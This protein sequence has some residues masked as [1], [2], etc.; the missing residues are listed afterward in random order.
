M[1]YFQHLYSIILRIKHILKHILINHVSKILSL[2][3]SCQP[4]PSFRHL[5]DMTIP[6]YNP[7]VFH[8]FPREKGSSPSTVLLDSTYRRRTR[9]L[10]YMKSVFSIIIFCKLS[11]RCIPV[12]AVGEGPSASRRPYFYKE[13]KAQGP[14]FSHYETFSV[15]PFSF[16][17]CFTAS[18]KQQQTDKMLYK[19]NTWNPKRL[20]G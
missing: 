1:F 6:K 16:Y 4:R 7:Y 14:N 12:M 5:M 2:S 20:Q 8:W 17:S 9:N 19:T 15:R 10:N 11:K 18:C 3:F 13:K